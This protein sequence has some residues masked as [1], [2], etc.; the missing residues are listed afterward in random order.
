MTPATL[1]RLDLGKDYNHWPGLSSGPA[2]SWFW[3]PEAGDIDSRILLP[4][5]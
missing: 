5:V 2:D 3:L 1:E 4:E